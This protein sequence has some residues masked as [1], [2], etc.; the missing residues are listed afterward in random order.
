MN[1]ARIAL[2]EIGGSHDECIL[3][4]VNALKTQEAEIHLICDTKVRERNEYLNAEFKGIFEVNTTGAAIGDVRLMRGIIR[5]LK[6]NR[7]EKVVFNTAQG[8]HVRNLALMMPKSINCYGIIHTIRKFNDSFTQKIIH[9]MIKRYAVLSDDLLKRVK[10]NSKIN[11]RSFYPIEFPVEKEKKSGTGDEILIGIPGGVENRRKDLAAF[12]EMISQTPENVH[13]IFLGK[14]DFSLSDAR[15][16][17]ATLE[18]RNLM[19][20]VELFDH[21]IPTDEF[22]IRIQACD[23]LLPLIHPNTPSADEYIV[24]QISGSF[25]LSFGLKIPLL[26]HEAYQDEDDLQ[27]S[28]FFYTVENFN[29]TLQLATEKHPNKIV[30]IDSVEKWK[31]TF[32]HTNFLRFIEL[33]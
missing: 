17:I 5:Y 20:R 22:F 12:S 3:T 19:K 8:G 24:N 25:S 33:I 29:K 2:V 15:E 23:F 28:A 21:F 27:K 7:I 4:Q 31:N 10:P 9:K 26:I 32:Q 18:E 30:E 6:E 14:S 1:N 16:F 11:V 13:F